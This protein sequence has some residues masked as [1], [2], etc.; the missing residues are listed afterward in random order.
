MLEPEYLRRVSEGS[1]QIA[2]SLHDYIIRKIIRR[3]MLRI[4]RGVEYLLTS[5][6]VWRIKTLQESGYLLEDITAEIAKYTKRQK[7]EIK[8]AMEEAGIKALEADNK[9]YQ[10][11]GLSPE[12]LAQSPALIRLM[13]RNMLATVNEWTNYTRTT[14]RVAQ[15]LYIAECDIA[16]NKV[17]TGAVSYTQAVREAVDTIVKDGVVVRYP[18]GHKDTIETATARAV[19]TGIAQATGDICLKRMEEMDWDIVLVSAHV[20]A[21]TGDGGQNPGNHAW[22]QGQYF[23]RTGKDKRFPDFKESTGYGTIEGLCGVNCRHSFGSGTGEAKDNPYKELMTA[24]NYRVEQAEKRQRELERRI[25]KT[26]RAVM[27]LQEAVDGCKDEQVKFSMQQEL[28]RKSY[29]L[30]SQNKAYNEYCKDNNLQPLADRLRIAQW[31]REQAAR[32]RGAA[33]RYENAKGAD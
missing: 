24:D 8:A 19:R 22:W 3:I 2:S 20:G 23:S 17:M 32:A 28:D 9:V 25:R 21:R 6:D 33:R 27:G 10:A 15:V 7:K 5:S 31:G 13:E 16:Y 4:G 1:E 29:L 18:T 11:A 26:K 12:P 30:Q 14:A